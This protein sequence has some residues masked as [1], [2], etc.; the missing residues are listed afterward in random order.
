MKGEDEKEEATDS[1]YALAGTRVHAPYLVTNRAGSW[2]WVWGMR[3]NRGSMLESAT[4]P[5]IHTRAHAHTHKH[6]TTVRFEDE[7]D[8]ENE[9]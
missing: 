6:N 5:H 4:L 9:M 7:P 8:V 2:D 3:Y 1:S